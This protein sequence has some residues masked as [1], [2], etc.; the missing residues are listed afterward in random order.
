MFDRNLPFNDL[1]NLPPPELIIDNEILIKWG[2]ASRNLAELNKNILRMP[3]P[4]MLINTIGLREAKTS[5]AIENIFTTDDELY[6]AISSQIREDHASSSAKEVLRYREALWG[7]YQLIKAED[8]LT[9][10]VLLQVFQKTKNSTQGF[11]P[12]Q[13]LTVIRRGNSELRPGEV[14][15]TPPRGEHIIQDK[16]HNLLDFLNFDTDIDPLLKMAI[17][18]YQF[19]AIHPFTDGNGRTGR[20]LN[21]LYLVNQGLLSQPVLYLSR[22]ILENKAD[23]YLLLAG[24]TQ[25]AAWKPWLLFMMEAVERTAKQT[26]Q[27]IDDIMDQ[28]EVTLRFAKSKI[29]W[30]SNEFNDLLFSQPYVKQERF[31]EVLKIKSRTTLVKYANELITHGI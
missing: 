7:G 11:R 21:L 26:N 10:K 8:R 22:Y 14:I 27:M 9:E 15:Y 4:S 16:I 24:V 12:P 23:Y 28:K 31:K 13:S 1:P 17:A 18:H 25:R 3:N 20:I 19:E 2:L 6:R 29:S 5:T 30:Y